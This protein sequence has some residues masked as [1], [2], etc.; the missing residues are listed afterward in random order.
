MKN[1]LLKYGLLSLAILLSLPS[2]KK[3]DPP[4]TTTPATGPGKVKLEFFNNV[5]GSS[6]SLGSQWYTN[7]NG[8]SFTVSKFNYYITNIALK[9]PGGASYTETES[10]H[11][12]QESD[13]STLSFDMND[14]PAAT[15]DSISFLIG[16]DKNRNTS[17]AQTGALDPANGMF[18][19]WN[20]GYIMLKMEGGS[21]QSPNHLLE[22]HCG[23]FSGFN[24]S[25]RSVTLPLSSA[26]TV[27]ATSTPHV[28]LKADML[29]M[30]KQPHKIDFS[31]TYSVSQP[32]SNANKIADNYANMFTITYAGL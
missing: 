31:S 9:G 12:L 10:Y 6:L 29:A 7:E 21:P 14:I 16:V 17:G 13:H 4:V 3:K 8:D 18:W 32:D 26:I 1:T 23:G 27:S 24:N 19:S 25:V 15:Y 30:F 11:L 2:C 22:F 5:G 28:H 20:T